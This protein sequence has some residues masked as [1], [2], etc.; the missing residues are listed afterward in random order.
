MNW[1]W[2]G[3]AAVSFSI[4]TVAFAAARRDVIALRR[5]RR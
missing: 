2:V 1:A 5:S 4:A 3:V